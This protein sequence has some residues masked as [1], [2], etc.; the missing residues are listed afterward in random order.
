MG[1][2]LVYVKRW[3]MCV[4]FSFPLRGMLASRCHVQFKEASHTGVEGYWL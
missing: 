3:T 2:L 4:G 1:V